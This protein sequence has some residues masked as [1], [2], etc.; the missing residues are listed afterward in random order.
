MKKVINKQN[1][2]DLV[3]NYGKDT[4]AYYNVIDKKKKNMEAVQNFLKKHNFI[5]TKETIE[6][7]NNDLLAQ[8]IKIEFDEFFN[9][10][11]SDLNYLKKKEIYNGLLANFWQ[12]NE[13]RIKK[14]LVFETI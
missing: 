2:K 10:G 8:A 6:Q 14:Q 9:L 4:D 11:Y 13:S 3:L 1:R 7:N 12:E 5:R